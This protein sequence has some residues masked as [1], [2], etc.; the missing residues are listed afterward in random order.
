MRAHAPGRRE[1]ERHDDGDADPEQREAEEADRESGRQHDGDGADEGA[2]PRDADGA[3]R[4]ELAD[5]TVAHESDRRHRHGERRDRERCDARRPAEL[6]ADVER[7]PVGPG[8][9]AEDGAEAD[10]ADQED[11]S[12]RER[13]GRRGGR[14]GGRRVL[15]Q[16][17]SD[18]GAD[19]GEDERLERE[20]H[21]GVDAGVRRESRDGRPD[22]HT[23]APETVQARHHRPA[24]Q[25]LHQDALGIHRHVRESRDGAEDEQQDAEHDERCRQ[26]R[27]DEARAPRDDR[28]RDERAQRE[29]VSET[30]GEGHGEQGAD[31]RHEQC[32]PEMADVDTDVRR[33]PRNASGEAAGHASV[34]CEHRRRPA[35]R[36]PDVGSGRD[37]AGCGGR[38]RAHGSRLSGAGRHGPPV[39]PESGGRGASYD[40][41]MREPVF[42]DTVQVA[43]VVPPICRP[44]CGDPDVER[45]GIGP[46]EIYEFN[47]DTVENMQGGR[48]ANRVVVA[49]RA[50]AVRRCDV[51]TDRAAR[52]PQHLRRVPGANTA[53]VS[54]TSGMAGT[55]FAGTLAEFAE[56]GR[57]P[58][59]SGRYRGVDFAY[60]PTDTDL[61]VVAEIFSAVPAGQEPDARYPG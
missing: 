36:T 53:R 30:A 40:R 56:E 39:E 43:V 14:V 18:C 12:G 1:H 57:L 19:R 51:G 32:D 49:A 42:T 52:R 54:T 34:H 16:K 50:R 55:A 20:L 21:P 47:P 23:D 8:L 59:L 15:G 60:L 61:G 35:P 29:T 27:Q 41:A 58:L 6:V 10:E 25:L 17:L 2:R 37:L 9:L 28:D 4:T 44:R 11:G 46:W 24:E 3:N 33:D 7:R 13:E 31:P 5:H 48:E 22:K 38:G 26:R 45:Y